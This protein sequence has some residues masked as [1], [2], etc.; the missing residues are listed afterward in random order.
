MTSSIG[1]EERWPPVR[2]LEPL[3]ALGCP[4]L[5]D[6]LPV[7]VR[8]ARDEPESPVRPY[9]QIKVVS[10]VPSTGQGITAPHR[11]QTSDKLFDTGL[12]IS[13]DVKPYTSVE[14]VKGN[15]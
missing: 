7:C 1:Q 11:A 8:R 13:V 4:H 12:L 6:D 15:N 14:R 2:R 10:E 9:Y 3:S 5:D